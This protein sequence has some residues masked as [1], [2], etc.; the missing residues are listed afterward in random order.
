MHEFDK[1]MTDKLPEI[2]EVSDPNSHKSK[3]IRENQ[4][5]KRLRKRREDSQK[6]ENK[7]KNITDMD[8]KKLFDTI[9]DNK[10]IFTEPIWDDIIIRGKK[11]D[12][13]SN[14][15]NSVNLIKEELELNS[16]PLQYD[17]L[18]NFYPL[19]TMF[20]INDICSVVRS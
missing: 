20:E 7:K 13:N 11:Y 19:F 4:E 9:R 12:K 5:Y 2:I 3:N 18:L 16:N 8:I 6:I 14:I 17:L 15:D 1:F 10:H